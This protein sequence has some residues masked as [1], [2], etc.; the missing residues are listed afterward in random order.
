MFTQISILS[1]VHGVAMGL[2]LLAEFA[3]LTNE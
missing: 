2:H 1:I 3:E